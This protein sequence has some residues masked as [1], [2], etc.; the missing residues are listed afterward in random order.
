MK[1]TDYENNFI[2]GIYRSRHKYNDLIILIPFIAAFAFPIIIAPILIAVND[3]ALIPSIA[4]IVLPIPIVAAFLYIRRNRIVR[5]FLK[6]TDISD[7][8]EIRDIPIND[9]NE[10]QGE[11]YY[12]FLYS[13]KMVAA[14]YNWLND[15]SVIEGDRVVLYKTDLLYSGGTYIILREKDLNITDENREQYEKESALLL[16]GRV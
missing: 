3:I 10:W 2:M 4:M 11:K 16:P 5:A 15:L 8:V 7:K 6:E 9:I 14:I 13:E 12:P 1:K